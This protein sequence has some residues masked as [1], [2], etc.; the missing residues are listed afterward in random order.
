MKTT[1]QCGKY[2]CKVPASH[3]AKEVTGRRY[4]AKLN[5]AMGIKIERG[6][7]K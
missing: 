5:T 6:S 1:Q 3:V 7:L 2:I 4:T